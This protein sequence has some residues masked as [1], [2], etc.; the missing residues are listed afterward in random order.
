MHVMTNVVPAAPSTA[1][2]PHVAPAIAPI[3]PAPFTHW[4]VPGNGALSCDPT[5]ALRDTWF[6]DAATNR[7]ARLRP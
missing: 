1:I 7:I 3:G 6:I 4:L 5:A 2:L